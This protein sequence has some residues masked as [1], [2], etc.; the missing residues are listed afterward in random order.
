MSRDPIIEEVFLTA[1]DAIQGLW[2][3]HSYVK[4]AVETADREGVKQRLPSGSFRL[5]HEWGKIL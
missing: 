1:D 3:L 2:G 4:A 5:T